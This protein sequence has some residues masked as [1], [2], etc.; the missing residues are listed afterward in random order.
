MPGRA[1]RAAGAAAA[2]PPDWGA[3]QARPLPVPG[4]VRVHGDR[5]WGRL[6]TGGRTG[7]SLPPR[8][9]RLGAAPSAALVPPGAVLVPFRPGAA[10]PSGRAPGQRPG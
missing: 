4:S 1:G 2:A 10:R 7:S 8:P 9:S 6:V 3:P 5:P